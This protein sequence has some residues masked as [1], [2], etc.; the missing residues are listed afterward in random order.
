MRT[1]TRFPATA[2]DQTRALL[3]RPG[4]SCSSARAVISF[5]L[6][7][8]VWWLLA[9]CATSESN[10][11]PARPGAGLREYQALVDNLRKAVVSSTQSVEALQG[12]PE[13]DFNSAYGRFTKAAERLEVV[14]IE[15]RAR[16]D[17]MEKRG[18]AYFEEWTEGISA[19]QT[20]Q[21]RTEALAGLGELRRHFEAILGQSR[22]VR[23]AF[24]NY[25]DGLRGL[26]A[27]TASEKTRGALAG[28]K[29]GPAQVTADGHSVE[30]GLDQLSEIL[31]TA[32]AAVEKAGLKPIKGGGQ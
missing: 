11:R 9:G 17:A 15:A 1:Q 20:G 10:S 12:A 16:A 21:A 24:R 25:L 8:N 30:R 19:S 22:E 27:A 4:M 7:M 14:S 18:H 2:C 23:Q 31:Q 26:R 5:S 28:A 13:K 29:P 6:L 32:R 3:V